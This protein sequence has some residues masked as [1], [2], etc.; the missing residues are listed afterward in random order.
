MGIV[1]MVV[2]LFVSCAVASVGYV[3]DS[4]STEAAFI[5]TG[6]ASFVLLL[7]L[8]R[9]MMGSVSGTLG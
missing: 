5:A 6:S 9:L 1:A 8:T 3:I 7:K 2:R 4:G